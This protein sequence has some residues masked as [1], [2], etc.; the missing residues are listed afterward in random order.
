MKPPVLQICGYKNSGKTTLIARL[1][2]IFNGMNIRVAVIKHDLHGFEGDV[3]ETDTYKL[4]AAGA[5]ATAITSPWRTA[6]VEEHE[7]PLSGLIERFRSYDLIL[8]EGFKEEPY[9]KLVM[10]NKPE[11]MELAQR[12]S[13]VVA[14]IRRGDGCEDA[15]EAGGSAESSVVLSAEAPNGGIP[16][17][18]A[19]EAEEIAGFILRYCQRGR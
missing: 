3:E 2:A 10:V 8:V 5:A 13:G 12:L 18:R 14:M 15:E 1:L 11:D 7:T 4:R 17:F 16:A 19:D 6:V 9:P